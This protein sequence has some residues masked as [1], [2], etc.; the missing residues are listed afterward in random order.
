MKSYVIAEFG[1]PLE[2]L[3][4]P[5]FKPTGT[6]VL[7]R[8]TAAGVCHS[9]IHMWEGY[10]DMG[11]GKKMLQKDRGLK[12]PHTPGHEIVGEVVALGPE[13][14]GE[15]AGLAPGRQ[16][17]AYPWIGC[18]HCP[19]CEAGNENICPTPCF[20]GVHRPGG[21]ADYV[22]VPH[23]R[24]LI[25]VTD[26]PMEEAAPYAC[27]GVTTYSA[28]R[29]IGPLMSKQAV[30]LVGAGGLGLM[31]LSLHRAMG[32]KAAVVVDVDPAKR[33]AALVAGAVAAID[34]AAPDVV[35]QIHAAGGGPVAAVVDLVGSGATV[36]MAINCVAKGGKVIVVGL[37]GGQVTISTPLFPQRALTVQ[38]SYVGNLQE[39]RDLLALVREGRVAP[40]PFT[41][42]PLSEAGNALLD[43]REGK[44]LGRAVLTAKPAPGGPRAP[45]LQSF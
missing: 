33:D 11:G 7:L 3:E 40:I 36:E 12:L 31:A 22:L 9:D 15:A 10:F 32:G 6:E 21:Y 28:L 4:H 35:A 27:S 17:L 13:A 2:L 26:I 16:Y 39:L 20:L 19:M 14:S 23:P 5:T 30:V 43:L 25:D 38:G 37:F 41:Q 24:Y 42:R 44:V 8:V 29:K 34:G 1:A 18:G 45:L